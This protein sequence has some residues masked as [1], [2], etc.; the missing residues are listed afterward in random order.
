MKKLLVIL[1]LAA[2]TNVSIASVEQVTL[3]NPPADI[4]VIHYPNRGTVT[5]IGDLN[6]DG[7]KDFAISSAGSLVGPV[8]V[9]YGADNLQSPLVLNQIQQGNSAGQGLNITI[10]SCSTGL[11][12]PLRTTS[13]DVDGDGAL[14]LVMLVDE[15]NVNAVALFAAENLNQNLSNLTYCDGSYSYAFPNSGIQ[16]F[17][18]H[19]LTGKPLRNFDPLDFNQDGKQ[20][21]IFTATGVTYPSAMILFGASA[22][23]YQ[24]HTLVPVAVAFGLATSPQVAV[25]NSTLPVS[26]ALGD[27]SGDGIDDMLVGTFPNSTNSVVNI[28]YGSSTYGQSVTGVTAPV[29]SD[30]LILLTNG[31]VQ[32]AT[33]AGDVN[34]DGLKDIMVGNSGSTAPTGTIC[35]VN[36]K[37]GGVGT[38]TL[39][40][41]SGGNSGGFAIY[42]ASY[43]GCSAFQA[44]AANVNGDAFS[45]IVIAAPRSGGTSCSNQ[46]SLVY[47]VLGRSTTTNVYLNDTTS[48][49]G[50]VLLNDAPGRCPNATACDFTKGGN[51]ALTIANLG[52]IDGDGADNIVLGFGSGSNSQSYIFGVK[53]TANTTSVTPAVSESSAL[54]NIIAIIF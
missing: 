9:I 43:P 5:G 42:G 47:V 49:D 15:G 37:N 20:D 54:E 36:G 45:D 17:A 30:R 26:A 18:V 29:V 34:G 38:L 33:S 28:Y 22:T 27:T 35:V 24:N 40:N 2:M 1:S 23:T 51:P 12:A 53:Q 13:A 8:A 44:I 14:D 11:L 46:L 10:Y 32:F 19:G 25:V 4:N 41:L 39:D 52:D 31:T 7:K 6:G 3:S 16:G 21:F 48:F 50:Y